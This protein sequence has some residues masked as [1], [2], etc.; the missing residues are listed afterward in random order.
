MLPKKLRDQ[1]NLLP[2]TEVEI[3]TDR[4]GI[5]VRPLHDAP[6]LMRKHG[7][8]VHHGNEP[9]EIDVV[10]FIAAER[11]RRGRDVVAEDPE[12]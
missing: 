5:R 10:G 9:T 3:T 6:S 7:F 12:P 2:G 4:N 1:F 11:E 8:L